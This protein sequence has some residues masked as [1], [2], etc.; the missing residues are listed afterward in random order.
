MYG[1]DTGTLKVLK[2]TQLGY[3]TVWS[4]SGEQGKQWKQ[5][6]V[7]LGRVVRSEIAIRG[8]VGPSATGDIAIDDITL[9]GC[10]AS[11]TPLCADNEWTCADGSCIN[12]T[13]FCDGRWDCPDQSD[14]T[15]CGARTYIV[16]L[17][18]RRCFNGF[19]RSLY[20]DRH[21]QLRF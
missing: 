6:N 3:Q 17:F 13:E 4:L 20:R 16:V 11:A 7:T 14:E 15:G 2:K 12:A 8:I 18:R 21:G 9:F 10:T 5:A 1:S 19:G